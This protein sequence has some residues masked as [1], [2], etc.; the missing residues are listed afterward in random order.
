MQRNCAAGEGYGFSASSDIMDGTGMWSM[1]YR[2]EQLDDGSLGKGSNNEPPEYMS[3]TPPVGVN[4]V[5]LL[6]NS[7]SEFMG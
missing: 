2:G 3:H 6:F 7:E 4:G 5:G 1:L